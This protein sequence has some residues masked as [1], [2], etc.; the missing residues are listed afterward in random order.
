M[1][2]PW[3]ENMVRPQLFHMLANLLH[4]VE[5]VSGNV[6]SHHHLRM[7]GVRPEEDIF[8]LPTDILHTELQRIRLKSTNVTVD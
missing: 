2:L 7:D 6:S 3:L 8:L 1:A 5:I 4:L